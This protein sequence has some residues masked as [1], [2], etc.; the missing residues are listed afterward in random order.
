MDV[1]S[2]SHLPPE[3]RDDRFR[4]SGATTRQGTT[5]T[6]GALVLSRLRTGADIG[7]QSA[8]FSQV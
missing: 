6:C 4:E 5:K 7:D 3:F 1:P 2:T 8:A